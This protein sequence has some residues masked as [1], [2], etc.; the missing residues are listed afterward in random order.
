MLARVEPPR[1]SQVGE[2]AAAKR[3][4]RAEEG[5]GLGPYLALA[6]RVPLR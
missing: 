4:T 1:R 3:L 6:G 2:A 5:R